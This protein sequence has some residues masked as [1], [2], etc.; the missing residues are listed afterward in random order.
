MRKKKNRLFIIIV[1]MIILLFINPRTIN[2]LKAKTMADGGALSIVKEIETTYRSQTVYEKLNKG[3]IKYIE[4][5]LIYYNKDGEQLWSKNLGIVNPVIKTNSNSVYIIDKNTNK[6]IR[7]NEDGK[8]IYENTLEKPYEDFNICEDNYAIIYHNIEGPVK[9][10]T[11]MNE[12]G[13]KI[14]E[15]AL[16]DDEVTN[17]DISKK[18]DRIS[19]STIGTDEGKLNN[20]IL[21][22]DLQGNL[23]GTKNLE[24]NIILNVFFNSKSDLIAVDE[25]NIFSIDNNNEVKWQTDFNEPITLIDNTNEDYISIYGENRNKNS[26]IYSSNGNKIKKI[27]YEGELIDE[28]KISDDIVGLDNYKNGII[29]HSL[30]TLFKYDKD[31]KLQF[32]YPYTSDIIESFILSEHNIVIVTKEKNIFL[33]YN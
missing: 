30:R 18:N 11:I 8:G 29:A 9:Y 16:G 7:I 6:I 20:K 25:K 13:E 10:F 1:F 4:G 15:I 33:K 26:I 31:G 27:S 2:Y 17:L 21:I 32:E 14:S 19:I 22:Y 23:L 3:L 5:I 24:N 28:M 12:I